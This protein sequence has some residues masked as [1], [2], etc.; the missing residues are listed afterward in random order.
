[1]PSSLAALVLVPLMPPDEKDFFRPRGRANM[2]HI[3][4]SRPDSGLG[5]QVKSLKPANMAHIRQSRPDFGLGFQVKFPKTFLVVPSSLVPPSRAALVRLP[6]PMSVQ[7][8]LVSS[9]NKI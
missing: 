6:L 4:Q 1:M 8:K 5:F 7:D 3:G 9:L 2:V